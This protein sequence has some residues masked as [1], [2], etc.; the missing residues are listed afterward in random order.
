MKYL[1]QAQATR[2]FGVEFR[3]KLEAQYA[4]WF[5]EM[6]LEWS[7][8][9]SPWH[10]F[11]VNGIYVEIK[12]FCQGALDSAAARMPLDKQM[13]VFCGSPQDT[14]KKCPPIDNW[15][16]FTVWKSGPTK[17][18]ELNR[19]M[20]KTFFRCAYGAI[21]GGWFTGGFIQEFHNYEI[22]EC[23]KDY[24]G[25]EEHSKHLF[26]KLGRT[27]I[28]IDY[29]HFFMVVNKQFA[30]DQIDCIDEDFRWLSLSRKYLERLTR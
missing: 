30:I 15:T 9:D 20:I 3:S 7:Y 18:Y 2:A 11:I 16:C 12:P 23:S 22:T 17:P 25:R 8:S 14:S 1:Y 5:Q 13:I 24:R 21:D 10:D 27:D 26:V 19:C 6:E 28:A 29:D 4:Y